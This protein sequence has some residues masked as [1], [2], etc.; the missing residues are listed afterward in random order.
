MQSNFGNAISNISMA[1][2]LMSTSRNKR[3]IEFESAVEKSI[4]C[5]AESPTEL[6]AGVPI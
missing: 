2:S 5:F 4:E 6:L 3:P 1:I